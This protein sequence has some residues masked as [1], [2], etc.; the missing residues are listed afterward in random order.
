MSEQEQTNLDGVHH[1]LDSHVVGLP[2][3]GNTCYM[4]SVLQCLLSV[5]EIAHAFADP[6][7]LVEGEIINTQSAMS[8]AEH[9]LNGPLDNP[10]SSKSSD[11]D[12]ETHQQHAARHAADERSGTGGLLARALCGLVRKVARMQHLSALDKDSNMPV[13]QRPPGALRGAPLGPLGR[14][15]AALDQFCPEFRA[16]HSY[17]PHGRQHDAMQATQIILDLLHHDLNLA[18][19]NTAASEMALHAQASP[20]SHS[21]SKA[22]SQLPP[23][24]QADHHWQHHR[25]CDRS[26]IA[27]AFQMQQRSRLSW[28]CK[29]SGPSGHHVSYVFDVTNSLALPLHF[30]KKRPESSGGSGKEESVER[31]SMECLCLSASLDHYLASETPEGVSRGCKHRD[32][33]PD[34]DGNRDAEGCGA[35]ACPVHKK[36]DLCR[37]APVLC[38]QLKRY[39]QN[40][41]GEMQKI[42]EVVQF[43]ME[44]FMDE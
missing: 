21:P 25:Q 6:R 27:D 41:L 20:R 9:A 3:L 35:D 12:Q 14:F 19:R 18:A 33:S 13:E 23:K 1:N 2:N 29:C 44:I 38:F 22:M 39:R 10:N 15:K 11:V 32:G 40:V 31:Q 5:P 34:G 17:D 7:L 8:N 30:P 28:D 36:L 37:L 24:I 16:L 4:N 42:E 26:V 43:P